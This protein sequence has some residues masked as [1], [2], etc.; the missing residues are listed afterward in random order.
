MFVALPLE[1]KAKFVTVLVRFPGYNNISYFVIAV[2]LGEDDVSN[3]LINI[4]ELF[5][6]AF[7]ANDVVDEKPT[8]SPEKKYE[9]Y[10]LVY[11]I[12]SDVFTIF[13]EQL[14]GITIKYE[15]FHIIEFI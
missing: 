2:V 15:P 9:A 4:V 8:P 3:P 10:R 13:V 6:T 11:V 14:A 5:V 12:K 7:D 1:L